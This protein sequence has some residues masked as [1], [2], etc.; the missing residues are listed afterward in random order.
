[1]F[2][3]KTEKTQRPPVDWEQNAHLFGGREEMGQRYLARFVELNESAMNDLRG[4]AAAED[5]AAVQAVAHK[6]KGGAGSVAAVSLHQS[7]AALESVAASGASW[8]DV[9]AALALVIEDWQALASH[10]D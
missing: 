1:M 6:I 5:H 9:E 2:W 3:S 10:A 8:S 4:A 7:A